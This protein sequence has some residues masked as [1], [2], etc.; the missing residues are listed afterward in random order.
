MQQQQQQLQPYSVQFGR[1]SPKAGSLWEISWTA[2]GKFQFYTYEDD[3][4]LQF[5]SIKDLRTGTLLMYMRS[6][7]FWSPEDKGWWHKYLC[8][9]GIV[10]QMPEVA[11]VHF[12]ELVP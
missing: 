1:V 3:S 5:T 9:E 12:K 7:M 11:N 10:Y 2:T 8:S 4:L 6:I